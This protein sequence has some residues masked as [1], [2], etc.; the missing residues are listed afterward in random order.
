MK[1]NGFPLL[2]L[3]VLLIGPGCSSVTSTHPLSIDPTPID[4]EKFEGIWIMENGTIHVKFTDN[5]LARLAALD[6]EE[7]EFRVIQGE[8]IVTQG[9]AHNFLS[10]RYQENPEKREGYFFLPYKFTDQDDLV[11][12]PP[13]PG[14]F[15]KMIEN[16]KLKGIAKKGKYST[17]ITITNEAGALLNI[18]NDPDNLGLFDYRNLIVLRKI[19]TDD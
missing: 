1:L 8:A 3:L 6:W 12:W 15:E 5:G 2:L 7:N 19:A 14:V 11:L 10:I 16:K 9:K 18:I 17:S 4:K 13:V